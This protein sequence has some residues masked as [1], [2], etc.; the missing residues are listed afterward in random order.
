MTSNVLMVVPTQRPFLILKLPLLIFDAVT[1]IWNPFELY[2]FSKISKK[3]KSLAKSISKRPFS[4]SLIDW[5]PFEVWL[6]FGTKDSD[7]WMFRPTSIQSED[8]YLIENQIHRYFRFYAANPFEKSVEV[9]EQLMDIFNT[10]LYGL[11]LESKTGRNVV[12]YL[13]RYANELPQDSY[14]TLHL[15]CSKLEDIHHLLETNKKK[16]DSLSV[17]IYNAEDPKLKQL[18]LSRQLYNELRISNLQM[19]SSYLLT[20][21][22]VIE[23]DLYNSELTNQYLNSFLKNLIAGKSNSRLKKAFIRTHD[24]INLREILDG[25][26]FVKRDPRTTKRCIEIEYFLG[27]ELSWIFG[28]YDI[29]LNDGRTATLQ[30]HK[31]LRESENSTVPLRW[32]QKYEDVNEMEDNVDPEA[33]ENEYHEVEDGEETGRFTCSSYLKSLT[34]SVW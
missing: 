28:G 14:Q 17:E 26:P 32:I 27:K 18:S 19:E 1:K 34:I 20:A 16:V 9:L 21:L 31:F 25:I 13:L 10:P 22:D 4:L 6:E 15:S 29:Q 23:I 24:V 12:D 5:A 11:Y 8:K 3:T 2:N 7:R 33:D 30:W